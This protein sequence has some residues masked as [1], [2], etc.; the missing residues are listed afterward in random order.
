MLGDKIGEVSMI[1]LVSLRGDRSDLEALTKSLNDPQITI[2]QEGEEFFLTSALLDAQSNAEAVR[3][4]AQ[5]L[6]LVLNGATH[7]ELHSRQ[8]ITLGTLH[9][10]RADGR[11]D[12]YILA[13]PATVACRIIAPTIQLTYPDGTVEEFHLADPVRDWMKVALTDSAVTKVLTIIGSE[14]SD[15][16]NLYRI[17]EIIVED[18]GGLSSIEAEGWATKK[19]MGLFKHTANSPGAIG[20]AARHGAEHTV[21]PPK[22]MT[23]GEARSLINSIA[24]AWLRSK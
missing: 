14:S 5:N 10:S 6:I 23:I 24:H 13:E 16:I 8:L 20:L 2:I 22:P 4:E 15:W 3:K 21:P 17:F 18:C 9:R 11:C 12:T 7:L 19:A 1:W